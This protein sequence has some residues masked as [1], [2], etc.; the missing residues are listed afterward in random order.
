MF[1]CV[2]GHGLPCCSFSPDIDA[3]CYYKVQPAAAGTILQP[4]HL[5]TWA[6]LHQPAG[7]AS[8]ACKVHVLCALTT[9]KPTYLEHGHGHGGKVGNRSSR[10][11]RHKHKGGCYRFYC[12]E[13]AVGVCVCVCVHAPSTIHPH[14]RPHPL[15][16]SMCN[17]QYTRHNPKL[18]NMAFYQPG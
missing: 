6:T 3:A 9:H 15:S 5:G 17:M 14:L 2:Y 11:L 18:A 8:G 4:S 16:M 1:K 10:E 7:C 13:W 12:R